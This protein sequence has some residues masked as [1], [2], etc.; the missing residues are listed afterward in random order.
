MYRAQLKQLLTSRSFVWI[1]FWINLMGTVYG[2]YWYKEQMAETAWPL[3]PFV[4]DSPTASLLF[5]L[6]LA[7]WLLRRTSPILEALA[8]MTCF[9][10]G[11]WC[12]AVLLLYGIDDGYISEPN[13][14][15]I[16][17]H[18]GMAIEVLLYSFMYRFRTRHVWVG[19]AWL[20]INDFFDY[21]FHVHPYLED[22][23]FISQVAVFTVLLS[24]LTIFMAFGISQQAQSNSRFVR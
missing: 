6:L 15:L 22:D 7:V 14:M 13:I 11:V 19:A 16:V 20:L 1:L 23:R 12:V 9:K 21:V 4:P 10:Y 5:T 24:L 2:Y 18:A 3:L 17:S 8:L